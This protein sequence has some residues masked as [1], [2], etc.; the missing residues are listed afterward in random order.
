MTSFRFGWID[1]F[2]KKN[3]FIKVTQY[4]FGILFL[5]S[6][7]IAYYLFRMIS[8]IKED[9]VLDI[10]CGDGTFGNWISFIAEAEVHGIDI[11]SKRIENAQT[12][13]LRYDLLCKYDC[14]KVELASFILTSSGTTNKK[15]RGCR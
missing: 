14:I 13:S 2:K 4:S 6:R 7:Q 15:N 5:H 3:L 12:T 10:G 11:F 9:R 8:F 1:Y